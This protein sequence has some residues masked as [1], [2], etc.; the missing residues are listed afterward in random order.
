MNE[1]PLCKAVRSFIIVPYAIFTAIEKVD[2][3]MKIVYANDCLK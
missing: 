1:A 3:F 2:W